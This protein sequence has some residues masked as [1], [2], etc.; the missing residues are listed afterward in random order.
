VHPARRQGGELA[1]GEAVLRRKRRCGG[2]GC[3]PLVVHPRH[4]FLLVVPGNIAEG[5]RW[6]VLFA[7]HAPHEG[8]CLPARHRVVWRKTMGRCSRRDLVI[9]HPLDRFGVIDPCGD[10]T[11]TCDSTRR[12]GRAQRGCRCNCRNQPDEKEPMPHEGPILLTGPWRP[13][14]VIKAG[15]RSLVPQRRHGIARMLFTSPTRFG[16]H[17]AREPA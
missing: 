4:G 3:D 6:C 14:L 9:D 7:F 13:H 15:L 16:T 2:A 10:I 8:G 5:M 11:E 1:A 17:G 12:R